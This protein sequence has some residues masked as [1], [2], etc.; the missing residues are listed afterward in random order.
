MTTETVHF[1]ESM[2]DASAL[3]KA[4]VQAFVK[5]TN[6]PEL[7]DADSMDYVEFLAET[8]VLEM[9]DGGS[10]NIKFT[11]LGKHYEMNPVTYGPQDPT[12]VRRA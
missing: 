2:D 12:V 9:W 6:D 10:P 7:L 8:D 11:L 1:H 5:T 4:L 3:E